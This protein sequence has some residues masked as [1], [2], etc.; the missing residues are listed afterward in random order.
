M[1][2]IIMLLVLGPAAGTGTPKCK[3]SGA[4]VEFDETLEIGAA[5]GFLDLFL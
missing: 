3:E 4:A 2:G 1:P 5:T